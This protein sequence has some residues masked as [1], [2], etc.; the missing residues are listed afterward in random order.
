MGPQDHPVCVISSDRVR[1]DGTTGGQTRQIVGSTGMSMSMA[2]T[3]TLI[4][5]CKYLI[6]EYM[7]NLEI[8]PIYQKVLPNAMGGG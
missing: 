6:N 4:L 1:R 3:V 2:N 7:G 5:F 8:T